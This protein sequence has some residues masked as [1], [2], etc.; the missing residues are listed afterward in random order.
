[1]SIGQCDATILGLC[2]AFGDGAR[3]AAEVLGEALDG[4]A[5]STSFDKF[6]QLLIGQP[7][8]SC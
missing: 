6:G 8:T 5:R 1:V 3:V 4:S 2:Q 7:T